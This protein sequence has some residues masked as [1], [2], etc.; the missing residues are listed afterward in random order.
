MKK[1]NSA[2]HQAVLIQPS[3]NL[4]SL[5]WMYEGENGKNKTK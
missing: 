5:L 1:A 4:V 3:E 2:A